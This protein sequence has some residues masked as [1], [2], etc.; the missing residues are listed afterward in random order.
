MVVELQ[1][2]RVLLCK[3]SIFYFPLRFSLSLYLSLSMLTFVLLLLPLS[4]SLS[5]SLSQGRGPLVSEQC[6]SAGSFLLYLTIPATPATRRTKA[7]SKTKLLLKLVAK[8][9]VL[10]LVVTVLVDNHFFE[11]RWVNNIAEAVGLYTLLV[12]LSFSGKGE[13]YSFTYFPLPP[14][15]SIVVYVLT[16]PSVSVCILAGC[17]GRFSAANLGHSSGAQLQLVLP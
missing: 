12:L 5:L 13:E 15:C 9:G 17:G 8:T 11:N 2:H 3:L 14:H 4:L 10:A 1:D 6:R 7:R 16:S